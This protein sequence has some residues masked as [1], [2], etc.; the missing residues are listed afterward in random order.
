MQKNQAVTTTTPTTPTIE[1]LKAG[2]E[3]WPAPVVARSEVKIFTGGLLGPRTIANLDSKGQGPGQK[4]KLGRNV[5]YRKD[6]LIAWLLGR[7]EA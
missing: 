3:A 5:A 4:I 7:L 2:W 1:F 6:Q